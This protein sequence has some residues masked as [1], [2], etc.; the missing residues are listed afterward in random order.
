MENIGSR[1]VMIILMKMSPHM[2]DECGKALR[3]VSEMS[4]Y[5]GTKG[6]RHFYH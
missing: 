4:Q 5:V 6:R 1:L 3:V 2:G